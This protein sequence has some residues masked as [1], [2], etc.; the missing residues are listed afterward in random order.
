MFSHVILQNPICVTPHIHITC[1]P[2]VALHT[3][4]KT[5]QRWTQEANRAKSIL[6][7]SGSDAVNIWQLL[8]LHSPR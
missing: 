3:P 8:K 6:I 1:I 7:Q 5:V 4:H 2:P